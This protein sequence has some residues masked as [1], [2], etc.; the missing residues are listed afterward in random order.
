MVAQ[1]V[2][3]SPARPPLL[4][5][6]LWHCPS[7]LAFVDADDK[8]NVVHYSAPSKSRP[9]D[10]NIVALD[11]LTGATLCNCKAAECGKRCW[12]QELVQ[13]AWDGH[14]AR[15]LASRFTDAQLS[16]AGSKAAHMVA[17]ARH[18]RF[19][20]HPLDQLN[21]LAAR[22]EYRARHLPALVAEVAAEP[23]P[24]AVLAALDAPT[25]APL[26][27]RVPYQEPA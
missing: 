17:W 12:H 10:A 19:R 8:L 18:R 6:S 21:L 27:Y 11:I 7:E 16:A 24:A 4:S 22:C 2:P 3:Q 25:H 1:P 5:S 20:V 9:G 23:V 14:P 13:A 26:V 15:V